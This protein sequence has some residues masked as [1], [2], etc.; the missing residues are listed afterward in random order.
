MKQKYSPRYGR[1]HI[2]VEDQPWSLVIKHV[3][4]FFKAYACFSRRKNC[5]FAYLEDGRWRNKF[6]P[7][8]NAIVQHNRLIFPE[9]F[10]VMKA[11]HQQPHGFEQ[12]R[13]RKTS[14]SSQFVA[15]K[16]NN[17]KIK[18]SFGKLQLAKSLSSINSLFQS[19]YN[20]WCRVI[21]ALM[22]GLS[23]SGIDRMIFPISFGDV[24]Y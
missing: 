12:Y 7:V 5:S 15:K 11:K 23:K 24:S 9:K 20:S 4:F 16:K 13:T 14:C 8:G 21:K 19:R 10:D 1:W 18:W 2:P 17:N 3:F 6:F 22:G